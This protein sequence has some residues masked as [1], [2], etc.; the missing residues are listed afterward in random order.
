VRY[1]VFTM[2]R[3]LRGTVID[4]ETTAV[5]IDVRGVGY[6]V[7]VTFPTSDVVL[8]T[9][10]QLFTYL[11]VRETA[12]TLYGF[13][14]RDSLAI[15]ELLL[16]IPKIGPKSAQQILTQA[17]VTTLREAVALQDASMLHKVSG[18]GKKTAE[19]IVAGLKDS[20]DAEATAAYISSAAPL[21][22]FSTDA[23]DALVAL[24][25]PHADARRTIGQLPPEIITANDAVRAAL[26]V[27]G[28]S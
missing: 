16:T 24:G 8:G 19:K 27:L 7:F 3:S 23:V 15:F 9:D 28:Q 12:L 5:T 1:T 11:A 25:Y 26:K 22:R 10:V 4:I 18:I 13:L 14:D 20:F 21:T 6:L 17:D 2:I